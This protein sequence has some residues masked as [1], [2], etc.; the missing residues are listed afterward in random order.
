MFAL[1]ITDTGLV[2]RDGREEAPGRSYPDQ[3]AANKVN[4]ILK[5]F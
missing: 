1:S 2:L 3:Q 5:Q 4:N